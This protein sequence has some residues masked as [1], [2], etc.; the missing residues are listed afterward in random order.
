MFSKED[1]LIVAVSGG[2][3]SVALACLMFNLGYDISLA[4]C[5]FQLRG[6]ESD[7]DEMFVKDLSKKIGVE[8][9]SKLFETSDYAHK[10]KISIQMAAR[11]LRYEWFEE[12]RQLTSSRYV[13]VA[14][15]QDDDI[16]TFF[17]NLVRGSGIRGFLG[18]KIK[19]NNIVRPLLSFS[20]EDIEK[21]LVDISQGYCEDSSNNDD[22]YLRN[23]IRHNLIPLIKSMNPSFRRTLANETEY[24]NDIFHIFQNQ[25]DDI[26]KKIVRCEGS[27]I[28]IS[29]KDLLDQEDRLI[30]LREIL[31][32]YGFNQTQKIIDSCSTNSGKIF[33]SDK[34]R[35]LI[36]RADMVIIE[37]KEEKISSFSIDVSS[38]I[39]KDP[40]NIRFSITENIDIIKESHV[41][42]LDFD[43]LNFPIIIR[44]WKE[45]DYFYPLGM[46]TKKKLSDFFIDNKISIFDKNE[47]WILCSGDEIVWVV[48][49]RI[50]DRFRI[51]D[52]TKKAYIAELF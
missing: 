46:Q 4:H 14:H 31:A 18:M 24:L 3:D 32:P 41:A 7:K 16:E 25:I 40:I 45:G 9:H 28:L 2:A 39:I 27:K 12:I 43:K 33:F 52:K 30:V 21:Y 44:K 15:H 5:N 8:Y 35:L 42:M 23:N 49:Y 47:C 34:Y 17:I 19:N 51:S 20:R 37:D 50:D 11:Q 10:Q 13:L 6:E 22:K 38:Q 29:K 48:G 36:D 26:K 1:K